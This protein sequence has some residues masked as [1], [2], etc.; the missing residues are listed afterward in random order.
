[1]IIWKTGD[2]FTSTAQVLVNTVNCE[3]VMGK[4]IALEFKNKYPDMFH[5]YQYWCKHLKPKGG[6]IMWWQETEKTEIQQAT[7]SFWD[8]KPKVKIGKTIL[9]FATKESWRNKSKIEWIELGLQ[10]FVEDI[11]IVKKYFKSISVAFPKLGCNNGGLDWET[12]VKPLMIKYLEPLE[13][14]IEIYE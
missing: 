9:C 8:P 12:Q 2:L 7:F 3:G 11:D 13:T 5:D 10:N 1:M 4:G 6:S 14:K